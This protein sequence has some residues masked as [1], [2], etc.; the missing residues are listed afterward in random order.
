MTTF[1]KLGVRER[2]GGFVDTWKE[3]GKR[4]PFGGNKSKSK[5]KS[6]NREPKG[7]SRLPTCVGFNYGEL[8]KLSMIEVI[9]FMPFLA[10]IKMLI[11]LIGIMKFQFLIVI[12]LFIRLIVC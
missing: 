3:G 1:G 11:N 4:F 8:T 6:R 5:S 10:D 7:L 12:N 2:E 9:S